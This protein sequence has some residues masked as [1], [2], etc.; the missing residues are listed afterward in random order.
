VLLPPISISA[1]TS[2]DI[3]STLE[4][5][6]EEDVPAKALP[7]KATKAKA[8]ATKLAAAPVADKKRKADEIE[9]PAA[10]ASAA[11]DTSI[12]GLSKNQRKKLAKKAKVEGEAAA[13]AAPAKAEG[14][15]AQQSSKQGQKVRK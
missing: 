12:D 3:C 1:C 2:S 4:E 9:S 8:E 11:A 13:P 10:K 7:T 14:K 5:L 15:P 6:D